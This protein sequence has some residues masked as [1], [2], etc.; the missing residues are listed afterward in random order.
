[1]TRNDS[2]KFDCFAHAVDLQAV[3][4]H[5]SRGVFPRH[6]LR[7]VAGN[8]ALT[9]TQYA[10]GKCLLKTSTITFDTFINILNLLCL[11]ALMEQS[12]TA[13]LM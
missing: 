12:F 2:Y 6:T 5:I 10:Y 9:G 7:Q 13:G 1:M 3:C 4:R 11:L 8:R